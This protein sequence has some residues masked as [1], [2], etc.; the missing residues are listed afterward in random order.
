MHLSGDA[1]EMWLSRAGERH[2]PGDLPPGSYQVMMSIPGRGVVRG[3]S[4]D[5]AAGQEV[6]IKCQAAFA[7]CRVR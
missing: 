4:F 3:A 7:M 2:T 1:Q 6:H 5:L